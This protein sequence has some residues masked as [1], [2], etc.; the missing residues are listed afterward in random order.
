MNGREEAWKAFS[1][2]NYGQSVLNR[3]YVSLTTESAKIWHH[4]VT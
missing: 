2:S 3:I 1:E 4:E